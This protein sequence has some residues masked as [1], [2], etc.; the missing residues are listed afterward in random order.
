MLTGVIT[1][2]GIEM[3]RKDIK[4]SSNAVIAYY[5]KNSKEQQLVMLESNQ[6]AAMNF[7]KKLFSCHQMIIFR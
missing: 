7:T 1:D 6:T 2:D 3:G 4:N 5:D